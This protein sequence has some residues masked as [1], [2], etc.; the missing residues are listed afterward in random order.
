MEFENNEYLYIYKWNNS[1]NSKNK[2]QNHILK[3]SKSMPNLAFKSSIFKQVV[4][5]TKWNYIYT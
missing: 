3:S 5:H 2:T 4:A 1:M